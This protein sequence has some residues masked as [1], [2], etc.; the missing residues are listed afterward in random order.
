MKEKI[1]SLRHLMASHQ[2]QAYLIPSTDPHQSEYVPEFWQRRQFVSGFTG[3]AG[4]VVVTLQK[5]GLWTDSRYYLQAEQQLDSD[6]FTLF[7]VGQPNVPSWQ[8]WVGTE[9]KPGDCLG[10]DPTLISHKEFEQLK[11]DLAL[12]QISIKAI[13]TNLVDLIRDSQPP[14]PAGQIFALSETFAGESVQNKLERLR[15]KIA[16]QNAR[17]HIVTMLDAIAWLLNIRG[18]DVNFNPVVIAYVLVTPDRAFLFMDPHKAP[19]GLSAHFQGL[20]EIRSYESF[21]E[22]IRRLAQSNCRVWL[23]PA[24][25]NQWIVELLSPAD[26]IFK[27]SPIT[28]FKAIKNS[29][30]ISGI[31]NAH[32]RDG[33]AMVKFLHWLETTLPNQTI[34][35]LAAAEKV[36]EFRSQSENFIG[37]SFETISSYASHGAIIHYA[38]TPETDVP[39]RPEGLYLIDSGGQYLDGTTDIT[40][41]IALGPVTAVQKD[42]FTRV[43]RGLI[44]LS[45][46]AFPQGTA[47]KQLDTIAREPLWEVG[48]NFGHGTGHGVGAFLNVHEGPHAISFY[49]CIGIGLEPGMITTN[50][51]GFYQAGEFGLRTE[52]ILVVVP[53]PELS[54]NGFNF[55]RFE[56]LTLCPIDTRLIHCDQLDP[57][58]LAWLN[59]Y[60]RQVR[61]ILTPLLN[62]D[63]A[64][65]LANAT[66]PLIC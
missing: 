9:L 15:A 4:E 5:A 21:P 42:R 7:K 30:E 38:V 10:L 49:R 31:K 66:Q 27:P 16:E 23:D 39:L 32:I 60:H 50:E 18:T 19:D 13:P 37:P 20:V 1:Q 36:N 45:M 11:A 33:V 64:A 12:K 43:L 56:T 62:A 47:G 3:S 8:A 24:T 51:P 35:E 6:I 63:Q 22:E 25:V 65:W 2:I 53:A 44:R 34:T 46:T 59:Q 14:A 48:L 61:E 17:A 54:Q 28:M 40:R 41:T 55:Y 26:L 29:T 58:E 52:N 57:K